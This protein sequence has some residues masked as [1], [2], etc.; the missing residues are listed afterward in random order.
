MA[1]PLHTALRFNSSR[2]KGLILHGQ[3]ELAKAHRKM[4]EKRFVLQIVLRPSEVAPI[5]KV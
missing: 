3:A 4:Q 1:S 2:P 5:H